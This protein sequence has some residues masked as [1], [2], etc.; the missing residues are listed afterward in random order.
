MGIPKKIWRFWS[1]GWE[2]SPEVIKKCKQSWEYYNPGWE[3]YDLTDENLNE[4]IDLNHFDTS[5]INT[6][7]KSIQAFSDVIRI[8][9][10]QKHGGIWIDATVWCEKPVESW[11]DLNLEF[12]AF[13]NPTPDKMVASWFLASSTHGYIVNKWYNKTIEYWKKRNTHI[14]GRDF[15]FHLLFNEIYTTDSQVKE[16]WDSTNKIKCPIH[17]TKGPHHFAPYTPSQLTGVTPEFKKMIDNKIS[18]VFKLGHH[19][20]LEKYDKIKY[21]FNTL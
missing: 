14:V 15:W 16:I 10:L 1:Q 8:H 4:Y 17:S 5:T 2:K 13:S 20:P 9:L 3:F 11:L 21:L 12:F 6:F 19:W 7:S 18:P